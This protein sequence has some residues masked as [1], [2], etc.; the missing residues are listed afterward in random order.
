MGALVY[1]LRVGIPSKPPPRG[2]PSAADSGALISVDDAGCVLAVLR[3]PWLGAPHKGER[4]SERFEPASASAVTELASRG[5]LGAS[6]RRLRLADGPWV[7][8][9]VTREGESYWIWLNDVTAQELIGRVNEQRRQQRALSELV[10]SISRELTDP[11]AIVQGTLEL[12]IEIG[13]ADPRSVHHHLSVALENSRRATATLRNLR[14]VGRFHPTAAGSTPLAE[15]VQEVVELVG[16]RRDQLIF[17]YEPEDLAVGCEAALA[18]RVIASLARQCSD[19]LG[20]SPVRVC[21]ERVGSRVEIYVGPSSQSEEDG[22]EQESS[23]LHQILVA[24]VGGELESYRVGQLPEFRVRLP[25]PAAR[26]RRRR[27]PPSSVLAVGPVASRDVPEIL[28]RD[29]YTCLCTGTAQ[30]ALGYLSEQPFA[31]LVTDLLL[32]DGVSG[33]SLA[34]IA[35]SRSGSAP[36]RVILVGEGLPLPLPP[37]IIA[38]RAPISRADLIGALTEEQPQKR[39][40]PRRSGEKKRR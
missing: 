8:A 37:P 23:L 7:T 24:S 21:A 25:A 1:D 38:L 6:E 36:A 20:R 3:W 5:W 9:S 35:M 15:I 30:E 27:A 40:S 19:A 39:S 31:A 2:E 12:L 14:L 13:V 32:D 28:T 4:V 18:A 22:V 29:G 17:K 10:G 16:P 11:M 34:D 26:V 33:L